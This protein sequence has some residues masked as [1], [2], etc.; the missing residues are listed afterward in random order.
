MMP[1]WAQAVL[2]APR[3]SFATSITV[4]P[5]SAAEGELKHTLQGLILLAGG[6]HHLQQHQLA[7]LNSLWEEAVQRLQPS[8]GR[9]ST[10]WGEVRAEVALDL[11][12]QRL[13]HGK[14]RTDDAEEAAIFGPLWALDRPVWELA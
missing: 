9:V 11:T 14:R 4:A 10:P 6:Y 3:S 8:G 7:G 5:R 12:I 2:V 1:P 13:E